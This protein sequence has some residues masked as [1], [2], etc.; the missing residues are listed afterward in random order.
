MLNSCVSM[1]IINFFTKFYHF[2]YKC[3]VWSNILVWYI[4]KSENKVNSVCITNKNH[5]TIKSINVNNMFRPSV[6]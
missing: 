1:K 4:Y 6:T 3:F 5:N 2:Q